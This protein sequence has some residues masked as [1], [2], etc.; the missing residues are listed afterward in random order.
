MDHLRIRRRTALWPRPALWSG[1]APR[2][3]SRLARWLSVLAA[4]VV[5]I[6][7]WPATSEAA[8][9]RPKPRHP[10]ARPAPRPAP[11]LP[12]TSGQA[13][14]Q[15]RA[16]N[17][18]FEKVTEL[19]NDARV[20]LKKRDAEARTAAEKVLAAQVEYAALDS[21]LK[22]VV[23]ASY[24]SVPFGRFNAL[25]TGTSPQ[26]YLERVAA[27][28][29]VTGRRAAVLNGAALIRARTLLAQAS[30]RAAVST[31]S[32]LA[33]DLRAKRADLARRA[34]ASRAMF[35]TLSARERAA[36]LAA[37][38]VRAAR[39]AQA[40]R[41]AERASRG[42]SRYHPQGS[43]SAV[44]VPAAGRAATAVAWARRQLGK[45]YVW[46]AEGPNTFDCSGLTMFVWAKAGVYLPHS[47]R[48]QSTMG[49][50]VSRSQLRPGDLV[51]F[52]SP[53]HHVGIYVG[54]GMMI[55]APQTN[56]VVRYAGIGWPDYAGARRVG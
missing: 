22:H 3:A 7:L 21:Q 30:A 14:A 1:P 56:D 25:L 39:A 16:Y 20:L 11:P 4:A 35:R 8:P 27:L 36:F 17:Q 13:L 5:S 15:L 2:R 24:A 45:A 33:A 31:A 26:D 6:G 50:A 10:A 18:E 9:G 52:G 55:N 28:N 49:I 48:M 34:A 41:A 23:R 51:F 54:D 53:V 44:N 42:S 29:A 12:R 37:Q 32:K 47:S 40:A 46:A 19:Y 43:G 38:A